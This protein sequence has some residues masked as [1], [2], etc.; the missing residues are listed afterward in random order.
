[1]R[2]DAVE[3]VLL[4]STV[5]VAERGMFA[6]LAQQAVWIGPSVTFSLPTDLRWRDK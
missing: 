3:L 6:M 1:M 5:I 4:D 2:S